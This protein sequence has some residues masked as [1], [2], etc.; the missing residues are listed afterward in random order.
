MIHFFFSLK[1]EVIIIV[2]VSRGAVQQPLLQPRA[3]VNTITQQTALYCTLNV[4]QP[5]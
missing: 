4:Y 3:A 5:S 2:I 1:L